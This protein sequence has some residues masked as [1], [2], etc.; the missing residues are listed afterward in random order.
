MINSVLKKIIL[1]N[2]RTIVSDDYLNLI[3]EVSG[4]Y[5]KKITSGSLLGV[6]WNGEGKETPSIWRNFIQG[7]L[8]ILNLV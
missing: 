5:G 8:L 1:K 4:F 6:R 3:A 7:I 2:R